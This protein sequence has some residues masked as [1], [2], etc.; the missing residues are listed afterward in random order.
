VSFHSLRWLYDTIIIIIETTLPT[1]T[2]LVEAVE[3]IPDVVINR[4]IYTKNEN[5]NNVSGDPSQGKSVPER[6][7]R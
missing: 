6:S 5:E 7:D 2:F 4:C 3:L 1:S